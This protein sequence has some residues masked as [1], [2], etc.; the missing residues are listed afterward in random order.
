ME[1]A[2]WMII[3]AIAVLIGLLALVARFFFRLLKHI[4]VA[5][6]VGVVIAFIWVQMQ[7]GV[8]VNPL[9]GKRAYSSAN[10]QFVGTV[11]A[12]GTDSKLGDILIIEQPGG[13]RVK[14]PKNFLR[15]RDR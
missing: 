6:V 7:P 15:L 1:F 12:S 5:V 2:P 11:V 13:Y 14:Y 9:I 10:G 3:V 4:I 8:P